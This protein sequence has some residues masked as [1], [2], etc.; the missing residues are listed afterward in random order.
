MSSAEKLSIVERTEIIQKMDKETLIRRLENLILL[1][2]CNYLH[3]E[4]LRSFRKPEKLEAAIKEDA[5]LI[6]EH[7]MDMNLYMFIGQRRFGDN[8]LHPATRRK[9]EFYGS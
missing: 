7:T 6:Q 8:F 5:A 3:I 4:Q 1:L 2:K 9:V